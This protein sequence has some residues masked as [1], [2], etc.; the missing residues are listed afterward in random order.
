VYHH[1]DQVV[2][3][4]IEERPAAPAPSPSQQPGPSARLHLFP[5]SG[6]LGA[7]LT[8]IF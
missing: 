5:T 2:Q 8:L 6:G 3:T 4:T 1:N 7:G